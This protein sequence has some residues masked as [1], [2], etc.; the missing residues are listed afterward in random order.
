[1]M[2]KDSNKIAIIIGERNIYYSEMLQRITLYSHFT[3]QQP[4]ERTLI[5]AENREGWIYAFYSIWANKGIAVPVDAS[6]TVSDVAY[7]I[8]DCHPACIWTTA[9]KL[10]V[11][12]AAMQEAGQTV[13][14]HLIED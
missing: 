4:K 3:P 7:I 6:S 2:I 9:Q 11:V 1:M 13:D 5:F 8:N 10:D 14:T 12:K